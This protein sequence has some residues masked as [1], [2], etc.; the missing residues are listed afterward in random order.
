MTWK[1]RIGDEEYPANS[2]EEIGNW[3][4]EG[5][6]R[7]DHYVFNPVLSQ[8]LYARDVLELQSAFATQ[9]LPGQGGAPTPAG[10]GSQSSL[11][12]CGRVF[13]VTLGL[14]IAGVV[15]LAIGLALLPDSDTGSSAPMPTRTPVERLRSLGQL[16]N[17]R[18]AMAEA[19]ALGLVERVETRKVWVDPAVWRALPYDA[20]QQ[21]TFA[22][23]I[24]SCECDNPD[25]FRIEIMDNRTGRRLAKW[26]L[27]GFKVDD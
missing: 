17:A 9:R 1:V 18:E 13:F 25:L 15:V 20:K 10:K 8:W 14:A 24:A 12:G 7:A 19:K 5:R 27:F 16:Q 2:P 4:Q 23:A 21:F 3:I 22:A 26:N 6:V 11:G